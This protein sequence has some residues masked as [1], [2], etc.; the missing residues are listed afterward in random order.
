MQNVA[1]TSTAPLSVSQTLHTACERH[2]ALATLIT[3]FSALYS[4]HA[5]LIPKLT[6]KM[7]EDAN[8]PEPVLHKGRL[9]QGVPVLADASL[10]WA[11]S[12]YPDIAEGL[13]EPLSQIGTMQQ[14]V[15]LYQTAIADKK[16]SITDLLSAVQDSNESALT[17][18]AATAGMEYGTLLFI[19]QQ[20]L[21][22]LLSAYV[23]VHNAAFEKI[24]W[25]EA[26]CPVCGSFPDIST[27]QRPDPDQS[28]FL[29]G[30][31]GKK[32]MHCSTCSHEWHFR[33]GTCPACNHD[34]VGA[35]HYFHVED[36]SAERV[37]YCEKCKTYLNNIDLRNSTTTPDLTVAPL[38]LIHL[39]MQAAQKKLKPLVRS[40]WNT[41]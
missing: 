39:D 24:F 19:T 4:A 37:E 28:E 17:Q 23:A 15:E 25:R 36:N 10:E 9:Q 20:I 1:T 11:E 30:G 34:E 35:I 32:M 18:H 41:F 21:H 7:A 26:Y 8:C 2:P 27:L 31:G 13:F 3:H 29:A 14:S 5:E 12:Y 22:S 38:T 40:L 16:L 6:E 33:R